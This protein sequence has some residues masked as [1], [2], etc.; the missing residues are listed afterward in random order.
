MGSVLPD[1]LI[2]SQSSLASKLLCELFYFLNIG[3]ILFI[4]K[5]AC[6]ADLTQ[7]PPVCRQRTSDQRVRHPPDRNGLIFTKQRVAEEEE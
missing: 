1:L 5:N 2:F 7:G 6:R 4:I 3:K